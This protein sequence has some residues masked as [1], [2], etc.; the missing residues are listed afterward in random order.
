MAEV[1]NFFKSKATKFTC[2]EKGC[3]G[4]IDTGDE[5]RKTILRTGCESYDA[6]YACDVCGRL[7]FGPGRLVLNRQ[8]MPAY[9]VNGEVKHGSEHRT[10]PEAAH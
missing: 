3:L 1:S 8:D 6:A 7:H 10:K 5:I 4:S 9:L 2:A